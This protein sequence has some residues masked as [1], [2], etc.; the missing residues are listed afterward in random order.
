[1]NTKEKEKQKQHKI[2]PSHYLTGAYAVAK[3]LFLSPYHR[4]DGDK[5]VLI[6][7]SGRIGDLVLFV[8]VLKQYKRL[9][10]KEKGYQLF[11]A[12]RNQVRYFLEQFGL[13]AELEFIEVNREEMLWSFQ[14]FRTAV[15]NTNR[16]CYELM[17]TPK[18]IS[19]IE[20]VFTCC[21]RANR[22]YTI[23][24]EG[25]QSKE[26]LKERFFKK[27]SYTDVVPVASDSKI[28]NRYWM[29]FDKLSGKQHQVTVARL[30]IVESRRVFQGNYCVVAVSSSTNHAKCWMPDRFA[31]VID[32]MIA[33]YG[34]KI[35]FTGS[36]SDTSISN[37]V[38][39][40][41]K[42]QSRIINCVGTLDL[43]DWI[44]LIRKA[45]L[46]VS[47]DSSPIHI[48]AAVGTKSICLVGQW[49]GET[50]V[51]YEP[52]VVRDDDALPLVVRGKR[53]PCYYCMLTK[54]TIKSNPACLEAFRNDRP[55]PCMEMIELKPV[56]DAV[57]QMLKEDQKEKSYKI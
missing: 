43:I 27:K 42:N 17:I 10:A 57:D 45:R 7:F 13:A 56:R 11:F 48:A 5:K 16:H 53:L 29:L 41:I 30:P 37:E 20:Y 3:H 4:N 55:Y 1:M 39:T 8:D 49:E 14:A 36:K 31:A 32:Y 46:V 18:I 28:I 38:I 50:F 44:A 15:H 34:T 9:Y 33:T 23:A 24:I 54:D 51:P 26:S 21:V 22:K 25:D 12:C 2:L 47:L 6:F 35:Y 52:D 19:I 40:L